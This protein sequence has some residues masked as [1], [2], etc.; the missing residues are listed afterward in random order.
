M[1]LVHEL[2]WWV[3]KALPAIPRDIKDKE[4]SPDILCTSTFSL[5][6]VLLPCLPIQYHAT[7]LQFLCEMLLSV[8]SKT[9]SLFYKCAQSLSSD[10]LQKLLLA[11]SLRRI[12]EV[13]V[14][15]LVDTPLKSSKVS[16]LENYFCRS[17]ECRI[18]VLSCLVILQII[19][20]GCNTQYSI[21]NGFSMDKLG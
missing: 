21:A 4:L 3:S 18:R 12:G 5:M 20:R 19:T 11:S 14:S 1:Q 15:S 17:S 8:S 2:L 7:C 16:T 13:F 10:F 9:V 6:S